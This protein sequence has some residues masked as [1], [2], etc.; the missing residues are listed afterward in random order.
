VDRIE[1]DFAGPPETLTTICGGTGG[2][3]NSRLDL[4][5]DEVIIQ[6]QGRYGN[7][8]DSLI[9]DTSKGK[10]RIYGNPD[11]G[12]ASFI[13][14]APPDKAIVGFSVRSHTF[15]DAIGVIL[16]NR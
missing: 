6:I 2:T 1:V 12:S 4:D 13:F 15:V 16:G 10:R 8:V 7:F 11:A 3:L 14:M 5:Q 9:I